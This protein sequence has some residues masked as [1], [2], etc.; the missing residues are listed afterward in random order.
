MPIGQAW[1]NPE[2][3][4]EGKIFRV[5]G[6]AAGRIGKR[7]GPTPGS[8]QSCTNASFAGTYGY[9]LSGITADGNG[10]SGSSTFSLNGQPQSRTFNGTYTLNS[11]CRGTAKFSDSLSETI[12]MDLV[13][14]GNGQEIQ[15]IQTDSGTVI[16]GAAQQ[17]Q[18][19]CSLE[20]INGP[21]RGP[22]SRPRGP[23]ETR[24]SRCRCAPAGGPLP[25]RGGSRSC[26]PLPGCAQLP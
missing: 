4:G 15:L 21:K 5:V 8:N 12:T 10:S 6:C 26:P 7:Q 16:S 22:L 13:I 25:A 14:A 24:P 3:G 19:N 20:T 17:Q 1:T 9:T 23:A 11:D 18:T 2:A